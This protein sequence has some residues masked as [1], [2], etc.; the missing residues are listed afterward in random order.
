MAI[1]TGVSLTRAWLG[2]ADFL[3]HVRRGEVPQATSGHKVQFQLSATGGSPGILP[4]VMI[5]EEK[6]EWGCV[7]GC[8]GVEC[9]RGDGTNMK[10]STRDW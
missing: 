5:S 3:H 1:S 4:W 6:R 9:L 7:C 8:V 2:G 10:T